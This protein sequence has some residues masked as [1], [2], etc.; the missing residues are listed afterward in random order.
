MT[1]FKQFGDTVS[2]ARRGGDRDGNRA[3]NNEAMNLFSNAA[4]GQTIT[5]KAKNVNV[6]YVHGEGTSK[7]IK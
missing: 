7:L 4:Y 6:T 1:R 5:N 2:E 3:T